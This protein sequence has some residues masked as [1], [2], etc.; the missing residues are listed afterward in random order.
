M[1]A[2]KLRTYVIKAIDLDYTPEQITATL[3]IQ[4]WSESEIAE[5]IV[6]ARQ[7][8]DARQE[9]E[10]PEAPPKEA[11]E[12]D[13]PAESK[14][15]TQQI[16][17]IDLS[18]LLL[19]LGG[20]IVVVAGVTYIGIQWQYWTAIG[21]VAIIALPMLVCAGAGYYL[22]NSRK[23][24]GPGNVFMIVA[25]LLLPLL[26][27]VALSEFKIIVQRPDTLGLVVSLTALAV[28][29]TR[30]SMSK[31]AS[32]W[33]LTQAA[34]FCSYVFG[35]FH[36]KVSEIEWMPTDSWLLAYFGVGYL[37]FAAHRPQGYSLAV[38]SS[39]HTIAVMVL[40]VSLLSCI[41][42]LFYMGD[43]FFDAS[44]LFFAGFIL[45]GLGLNFEKLNLPKLPHTGYCFGLFLIV[46]ACIWLS[47]IKYLWL[48]T[49]ASFDLDEGKH[50]AWGNTII[51]GVLMALAFASSRLAVGKRILSLYKKYIEI[52]ATI[53]LLTAIMSLGWQ[54]HYFAYETALVVA[55]LCFIFGG[56]IVR[57][58]PYMLLG[59]LYLVVYIFS[60]GAEYFQNDVGWP[61]TLFVAGL[62]SMAASLGVEHLRRRYARVV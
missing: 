35:L 17:N 13:Q 5:A 2:Q 48:E 33:V 8:I 50:L 1:G 31:E 52:I 34:G 60:T 37:L 15:I 21:R 20:M 43:T 4:G 51:G 61:V 42:E 30:A 19:Y 22:R 47:S 40:L 41:S 56:A 9:V 57:S 24:I 11:L 49:F 38:R 62:A 45:L 44:K 39:A 27:V 26:L 29:L 46:F 14:T 55:S 3:T 59:T 18:E 32:W 54:G 7:I 36:F 6:E 58:S 28:Y 16:A 12:S 53:W 25:G 23:Q 10:L